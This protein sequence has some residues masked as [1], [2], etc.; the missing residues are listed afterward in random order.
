MS[1][2]ELRLPG[3][4][5][6]I[7][8][9]PPGPSVGAFFDF[10]GTLIAGYSAKHL[11]QERVRK[12]EFG[13]G[14]MVRT[15]GTVL[16]GG[17]LNPDTFEQ[18]LRIGAQGW[19]GRTIEDLDEIG[20]R[21]FE[22]KLADLLFPEMREIVRA[23]QARGH[24][25]VLTSSATSFQV[26]PVAA[27]LGIDDI[28]CN[29]FATD[30]DGVLTGEVEQPVLWGPGK[31]D[32]AQHF[33]AERGIDLGHSYF[34]ADGDED[35]ALMYL[36]GRPRPTNPGKN[37]AKVAAKRGW[38]VL[39]FTSRGADSKLRSALG[40]GSLLPVAWA[41]LGVGLLKR[42]KRAGV[43]FVSQNWTTV[44]LAVNGVT[45]NV[46]GR[47]NAWS[48]RPAVF[49]FNHRNNFDPFIATSI[50]RKDFAAIAKGELR[51][52][53][54]VGT[55][56][57]L[58]D[59]AFVDR[60]NTASAVAALKPLEEMAAKGLSVIVAPEGTR[61]DTTGVGPFKKGA[62]RIAMAAGIPIV[63]IVIR[64]AEM[65]GGRNA[66]SMNPGSVDVAVLPPIPV[67]DWT[68][69]DLEQRI[70]G[71]RQLYLDTLADW[72]TPDP[73][74]DPDPDHRSDQR[75]V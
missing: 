9:S 38:P 43:N 5:A 60:S 11:L 56:G 39:R 23:H 74:T 57:R 14:E 28:L 53:P 46:T 47:E 52:D 41:G 35:T 48:H 6:E 8:A 4:V 15:L 58:L 18:V 72:P 40:L 61:L 25:V 32:A 69:D 29:R 30:S 36:V 64:N 44:S 33:A 31:A 54:I 73:A 16:S 10:D 20:L 55:L 24:T 2:S 70:A 75:E 22:K 17:G 49:I 7:A 71:V 66:R 65:I 51:S 27:Y 50:I 59:I 1:P 68:L 21:L 67:D 13:A 19:R 34:Y 42:S 12:G 63:P 26:E 45:V 3:S 37:L 62:F